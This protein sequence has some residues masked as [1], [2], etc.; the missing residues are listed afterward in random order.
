MPKLK[1]YLQPTKDYFTKNLGVNSV[2]A[3]VLPVAMQTVA[4]LNP[5]VAS[6]LSSIMDPGSISVILSGGAAGI[7]A[8]IMLLLRIVAAFTVNKVK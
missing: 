4:V 7:T 2:T 8:G 6:T 1:D 3:A 5:S